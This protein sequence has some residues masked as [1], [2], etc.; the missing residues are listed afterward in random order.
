MSEDELVATV[1]H[2]LQ[3]P[4]AAVKAAAK[5]LAE[6]PPDDPRLRERLLRLVLDGVDQ[7]GRIVDDLLTVASRDAGTLEIGIEPL[8]AV[9]VV[10]D[11]IE[12]AVPATRDVRRPRLDASREA[13]MA[14]A[15][16][17]RLRQV[18]TNLVTNAIVHGGGEVTV[19]VEAAGDRVRISVSDE[20]PGVPAADAERVFQRYARLRGGA[21]R[22]TGLGLAIARELTEAMGG[23]IAVRPNVPRGATFV[24]DLPAAPVA[25]DSR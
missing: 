18:T 15:D 5:A 17:Q 22:G 11:A 4:L 6:S 7:L 14:L 1:A 16:P 8:D 20:G 24:V 21:V 19:T 13:V 12:L 10:R 23:T 9:A 2:E 3:A 25:A